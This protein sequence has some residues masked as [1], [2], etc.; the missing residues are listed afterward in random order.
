MCD[1]RSCSWVP[2]RSLPCTL[3]D[4][5][6]AYNA[7]RCR[8]LSAK[9]PLIIGLFCDK[10]RTKIK[11]ILSICATLWWDLSKRKA[12]LD[13]IPKSGKFGIFFETFVYFSRARSILRKSFDK[14]YRANWRQNKR[15][16]GENM[17]EKTK[18]RINKTQKILRKRGA[19]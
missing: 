17:I 14:N 12:L 16:V 7:L 8:S 11:G 3:Q 5:G 10:W 15:I 13:T 4:G 6:D 9:E 1:G 19:M 18:S 2:Y